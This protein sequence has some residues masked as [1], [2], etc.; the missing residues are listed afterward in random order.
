MALVFPTIIA[1]KSE[2]LL[3]LA[4]ATA[5]FFLLFW[6]VW[7]TDGKRGGGQAGRMKGPRKDPDPSQT[8]SRPL[9]ACQKIHKA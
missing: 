6:P 1:P 5:I 7:D 2:G 9:I 3:D 4:T 8:F